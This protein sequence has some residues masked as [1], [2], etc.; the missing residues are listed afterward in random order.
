MKVIAKTGRDDIAVV[1]ILECSEG[2]WAECVES[3]APPLARDKKWVLLISTLY[4]CPI[5][6]MMCDA[7][8][9]Y[10]GRLNEEDILAQIEFLIE[11]RYPG[12][13]IIPGQFKIQFSRMGEPALNPAVLDVLR[14]LPSRVNAPGLMTTP[15]NIPSAE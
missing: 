2:R 8:G 11:K 5:K 10:H 14:M 3:V 4:G 6:C 12:G 7:G 9:H 13:R 1:Y 15:S